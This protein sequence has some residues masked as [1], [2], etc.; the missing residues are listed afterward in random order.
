MVPFILKI[1]PEGLELP[2]NVSVRFIPGLA[3]PAI[4]ACAWS[5][6][7]LQMRIAA[8]APKQGQIR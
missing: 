3:L 1:D 7:A 5:P 2:L 4:N 6:D 8:S